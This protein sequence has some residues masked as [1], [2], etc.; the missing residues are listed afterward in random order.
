MMRFVSTGAGALVLMALTGCNPWEEGSVWGLDLVTATLTSGADGK[1]KARIPLP[2][3][4]DTTKMLIAATTVDADQTVYV[5]SIESED[6]TTLRRL[7]SDVENDEM[8][9]GGVVNQSINHFNWPIDAGD[10]A[11]SGESVTVVYGVVRSDNTFAPGAEIAIDGLLSPDPDFSSSTL[12]V[13]LHWAGGIDEDPEIKLAVEAAVTEM[14]RIYEA[15][16]VVVE[17]TY[18]TFDGGALPRPGFGSPDTWE[19]LSRSTDNRA[20]DVVVVDTIAGSES[21]ILGAAGSIPGGLLATA[22]SGVILSASANAGPDLIYSESEILLLGGTMAHELGHMLGLFHP[23][24]TSY[25]RWDALDDTEKCQNAGGC[26]G[27]L[28]FNLMYPTALCTSSACN[29]QDELTE[30]QVGV[31]QRYTGVF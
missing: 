12:T 17:V 21:S 3:S 31:V 19:E 29:V 23:V 27:T 20:V 25:E 2:T 13:N 16:N 15:S 30:G 7:L 26:Q 18:Q 24:E 9:S 8:P 10:A 22:K 14:K 4:G 5:E 11:I 28:G 6:G 1:V